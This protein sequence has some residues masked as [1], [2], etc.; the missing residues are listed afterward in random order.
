[1]ELWEDDWH[2]F[3]VYNQFRFK[4]FPHQ[5]AFFEIIIRK[6]NPN[7]DL[8]RFS[9]TS[10]ISL[11]LYLVFLLLLYIYIFYMRSKKYNKCRS[12]ESNTAK[13]RNL[14]FLRKTSLLYGIQLFILSVLSTCGFFNSIHLWSL[15]FLSQ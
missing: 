15:W 6:R 2:L 1:M 5:A 7:F 14:T 10:V 8:A 3:V 11:G 4:L 9:V 13:R 12:V